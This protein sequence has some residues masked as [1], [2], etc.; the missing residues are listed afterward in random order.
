MSSYPFTIYS[1]SKLQ[2]FFL[3]QTNQ[4]KRFKNKLEDKTFNFFAREAYKV[5]RDMLM[6]CL[7]IQKLYE[8]YTFMVDRQ[9]KSCYTKKEKQQITGYQRQIRDHLYQKKNG[10]GL[11]TKICR[12]HRSAGSARHFDELDFV[13]ILDSD[14][15]IQIKEALL[16]LFW[17]CFFEFNALPQGLHGSTAD[18]RTTQKHFR[19]VY[20][21]FLDFVKGHGLKVDSGLFFIPH[22]LPT[23]YVSNAMFHNCKLNPIFGMTHESIREQEKIFCKD[24]NIS[25]RESFD[26]EDNRESCRQNVI[27][28]F[29][30]LNKNTKIFEKNKSHLICGKLTRQVTQADVESW[31]DRERYIMIKQQRFLTARHV[32]IQD[33]WFEKELDDSEDSQDDDEDKGEPSYDELMKQLEQV[34]K[35]NVRLSEEN[36]TLRAQRLNKKRKYGSTTPMSKSPNSSYVFDINKPPSHRHRK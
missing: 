7:K 5:S 30:E 12:L 23:Y 9:H 21:S 29:L 34:K 1:N 11:L 3:A 20:G 6:K 31:Y 16:A 35:E 22:Y 8:D 4:T 2:E 26:S 15:S 19:D 36:S 24:N 10:A 25:D 32:A 14:T 27:Q 28:Y 33:Q 17:Y 13:S 18:R